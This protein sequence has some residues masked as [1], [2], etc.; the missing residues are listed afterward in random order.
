M[1]SRAMDAL[2]RAIS[3]FETQVA[4]AARLEV[5]PMTISQ[6]KKRGVPEARCPDIEEATQGRVRCEELRPDV[7]WIRVRGKV[8]HYK[9]PVK[10]AA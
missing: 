10:A 1:Y 3:L 9:V 2:V 4:L 7:E 8:T 6:W 5:E